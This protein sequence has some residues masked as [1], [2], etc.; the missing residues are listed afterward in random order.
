MQRERQRRAGRSSWRAFALCAL[1]GCAATGGSPPPC[2]APTE[3]AIY[4]IEG[5]AIGDAEPQFR[6]LIIY[7][8]EVERYCR[9]I[10]AWRSN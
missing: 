2:P 3:A 6:A 4:E 1:V 5:I 9:G 10:E 8:A 7:I